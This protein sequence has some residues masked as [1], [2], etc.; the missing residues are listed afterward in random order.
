M[1]ARTLY[2]RACDGGA[3]RGCTNLG[4]LYERGLGVTRDVAQARTLYQR[5]CGAGDTDACA[6][7]QKLGGR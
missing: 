7:L 1:R 4:V 3:A 6:D 5:A 2:Q